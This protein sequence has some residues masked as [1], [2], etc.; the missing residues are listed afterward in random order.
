MGRY[1]LNILF[2]LSSMLSTLYGGLTLDE[3]IEIVKHSNLDIQIA[4]QEIQK[5]HLKIKE[6]SG[7][8]FGSLEFSQTVM[9]SDDAG[10]TFGFKLGSREADFASFGFDEFLTQMPQ[11]QNDPNAGVRLLETQPDQLNY[12]EARNYFQTKLTYKIPLYVGGQL[13]S[14]TRLLEKMEKL[15]K[16]DLQKLVREKVYETKK[17]FYDMALL[18]ATIKNLSDI[19]KNLKTLEDIVKN[20]IKEGYGKHIDLLEVQAR[21]IGVERTIEQM[22]SQKKLLYQYLS[23]LLNKKVD[24][25]TTS[26]QDIEMPKID[27]DEVLN[28]NIDLQKAEIGNAISRDVIDIKTSKYLPTVGAFAEVQTSDDTF[29]GDANDHKSFTIGIRLSWNLFNGGV[30]KASIEKAKVEALQRNTQLQLAKEGIKL[31]YQKIITNIE[32]YD[33]E[34]ERLKK[35][36]ELANEIYKNYEGFYKENLKPIS[37]VI[38]KQSKQI[39]KIM[40]LLKARNER[41]KLIISLEKL[42]KGEKI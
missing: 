13:F 3:A 15:S 12:P 22:K 37:D 19:L 2:I 4:K 28:G 24:D 33:A 10:N 32:N 16:L 36:L 6:V 17:S 21:R 31:Q 26:C 41:N 39:E 40:A 30:D 7:K 14:Y 38:V 18:N 35:E 23:F 20:M 34:I 5:S 25:I 1:I 9:R 42:Y 8:N 27:V 11:L 29:L